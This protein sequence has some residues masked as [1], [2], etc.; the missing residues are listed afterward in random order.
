MLTV[1]QFY[2]HPLHSRVSSVVAERE[3]SRAE[4]EKQ[5]LRATI[6][7]IERR[8]A[9][10]QQAIGQLDALKTYCERVAQNLESFGFEEKRMAL[11]ALGMRVK[12][13]GRDWQLT[14]S[15]PT[16][17]G[18][19]Y[20]IQRTVVAVVRAGGVRYRSEATAEAA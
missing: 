10:Q 16:G 17:A 4:K 18:V 3:I 8:L 2:L 9:E 1:V 5:Q 12:G 13:N 20:Q 7:E 6:A 14:C 15:V 19:T 11:E